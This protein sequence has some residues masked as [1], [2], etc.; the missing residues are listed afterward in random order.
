M[1]AE[2]VVTYEKV[3]KIAERILAEG[4][5]P[6]VDLILAETGGRRDYVRRFLKQWREKKKAEEQA[7]VDSAINESLAKAVFTDREEY[8]RAHTS[9]FQVENDQL[10][11]DCTSMERG[12]AGLYAENDELR[13]L[14]QKERE[15]H[16]TTVKSIEH[17]KTLAEGAWK[18]AQHQ[19]EIFKT[20]LGNSKIQIDNANKR[21]SRQDQNIGRYS[22]E[23]KTAQLHA[24]KLQDQLDETLAKLMDA[25]AKGDTFAKTSERL[26]GQNDELNTRIKQALSDHINETNL[27]IESEKLCAN[28]TGRSQAL[29]AE[30]SDLLK[31]IS[32]ETPSEE[33][34]QS[35]GRTQKRSVTTK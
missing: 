32:E 5:N 12:L 35:K 31:S 29:Q 23:V 26:Q 10:E 20:D 9:I 8:M 18:E 16:H 14:L 30:L 1:P 28:A 25:Q 11:N 19:I 17:S 2:T 24:K 34:S 13:A 21:L 33:E 4:G 3:V 15:E 27:R 6:T 7:L 22:S